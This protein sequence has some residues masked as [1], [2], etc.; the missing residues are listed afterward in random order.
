MS[1]A[2]PRRLALAIVSAAALLCG[3]PDGAAQ[4]SSFGRVTSLDL[5]RGQKAESALLADIDGDGKRDLVLASSKRGK[6]SRRTL[7]IHLRRDGASAFAQ[8]PDVE[9]TLLPD[10]VGFAVG[11]VHADAGAEIVLLAPNGAFALRWRATD[12]RERY[13]KLCD[14]EVLWQLPDEH[15][16][17]ALPDILRD[18]N[19]D[20]R[21][22]LVVPGPAG[23]TI[24]MQREIAGAREFETCVLVLPRG[25]AA[26]PEGRTARRLR[27]SERGRKMRVEFQIGRDKDAAGTLLDVAEQVPAPQFTDWDGDGRIDLLAQN[28]E[29]LLIW[30]QRDGFGAAPDV[31]VPLPL[32]VDRRRLLDISYAALT[33]DLNGDRRADYVL[34]AGDQDADEP[35]AQVAIYTRAPRGKET[36]RPLFGTRG[37]PSQL[38]VVE[39]IA[40]APELFDVDGDGLDDLV[41]GAVRFDALDALRAAAGSKIDAELYVYLNHGGTLSKRPDLLHEVPVEANG[42]RGARKGALARFV[43]DLTG[44]RVSEVLLREEPTRVRVLM[45]RK[46]K[47]GLNLF[48]RPLWETTVDEDAQLVLTPPA[49]GRAELL[50]LGDKQVL[51]V[52]F[53]K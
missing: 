34:V 1:R 30:L 5:P 19:G 46:T 2:A 39:G 8:D 48:E 11:D 26:T 50:V 29:E 4:D 44:D 40:G 36:E 52:R 20:G 17:L 10:V 38:L 41:L 33:S 21:V 35:R 53:E 14:A 7:R 15:E 3:A 45:L 47:D 16:T 18:V 25:G 37:L 6:R 9:F 28:T 24:A 22:D 49:E 43:G 42:L 27:G 13:A 23:Y 31:V 12:E 51:H 32:D